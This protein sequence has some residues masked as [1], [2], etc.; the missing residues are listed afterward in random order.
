MQPVSRSG[1]ANSVI[2]K[3]PLEGGQSIRNGGNWKGKKIPLLVAMRHHSSPDVYRSR[4]PELWEREVALYGNI[5][6]SSDV[7]RFTLSTTQYF[8][9]QS[10]LA[11][12]KNCKIKKTS[13]IA[14][15]KKLHRLTSFSSKVSKIEI[16]RAHV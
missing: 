10:P 13:K 2:P 12:W 5:N 16:G 14:A 9:I 7:L 4:A 8:C 1:S 6:T 15:V 11:T 3:L